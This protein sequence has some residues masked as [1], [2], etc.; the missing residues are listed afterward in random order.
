M[1]FVTPFVSEVV[2]GFVTE[3]VT[4]VAP[5]KEPRWTQAVGE[6]EMEMDPPWKKRGG[7][8]FEIVFTFSERKGGF[9]LEKGLFVINLSKEGDTWAVI[10]VFI[11][12]KPVY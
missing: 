2:A 6:P 10:S 3:V 5:E 11:L 9:G 7:S 4:E 12:R 8:V 1:A